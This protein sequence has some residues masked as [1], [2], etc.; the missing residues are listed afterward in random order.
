MSTTKKIRTLT[1]PEHQYLLDMAHDLS[2]YEITKHNHVSIHTIRSTMKTTK[3]TLHTHNINHTIA[4]TITFNK[5]TTTNMTDTT[6][7]KKK[8]QI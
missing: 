1:P 5:F 2:A 6:D 8:Y 3:P 7:L 4:L